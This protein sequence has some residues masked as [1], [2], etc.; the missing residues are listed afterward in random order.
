MALSVLS[1]SAIGRLTLGLAYVFGMVFPLLVMALVWDRLRLG[2]R[3]MRVARTV[4][5]R[6]RGFALVTNTLNIAVAIGFGVMGGVV[7]ALAGSPDMTGGTAAQ[8]AAGEGLVSAFGA[9]QEWVAPVPEPVLGLGLLALAGVFGW[10]TPADRRRAGTT[11]ID[12]VEDHCAS[13]AA[14]ADE[15]TVR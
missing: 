6:I 14:R 12:A 11:A 2:E 4:R 9:A 13:M 5:I 3:S 1:G 10:V 8:A 7:I 15:E